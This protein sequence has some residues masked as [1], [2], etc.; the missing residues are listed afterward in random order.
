MME[1]QIFL[2]MEKHTVTDSIGSQQKK[3][4]KVKEIGN[5]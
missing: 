4:R 1:Q 2:P 5:R 3:D